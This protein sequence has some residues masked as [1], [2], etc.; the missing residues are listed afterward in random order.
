LEVLCINCQEFIEVDYIE[1]HSHECTVVKAEV[2][3][4]EAGGV[5]EA[6]KMRILKLYNYL[7]NI[8][9]NGDVSPGEKNTYLIM[10]RICGQLIS[11]T[12]LT[13]K[14]ENQESLSGLESL[15]KHVKRT[16]HL[17]I[18][19]ER[20][21]ALAREQ[22]A[23][24]EE[25]ELKAKKSLEMTLEEQL[26]YFKNKA[27]ILEGALKFASTQHLASA[28]DEVESEV[29]SRASELSVTTLGTDRTMDF[30]SLDGDLFARRLDYGDPDDDQKLFYSK[31][32]SV[33]LEL[34]AMH[35]FENVP[36]YSVYSK[37]RTLGISRAEWDQ[38][39]RTELLSKANSRSQE[40][41]RTSLRRRFM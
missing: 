22:K 23:A 14:A 10:Q 28:L 38:F 16:S 12:N 25:L 2:L 41:L 31:C 3:K 15:C 9:T 30:D 19:A 29:S 13:H 40:P 37:A 18:Y 17:V 11:V 32:L 6:V 36:I 5:L 4:V 21:R 34:S 26:E 35:R 39:I 20:L 1:V 24:L 33:K 27:Q 7:F 8:S